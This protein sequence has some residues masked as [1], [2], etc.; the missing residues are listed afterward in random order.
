MTIS[1]TLQTLQ[2]AFQAFLAVGRQNIAKAQ[3]KWYYYNYSCL[4][5]FHIFF[6]IFFTFSF[7]PFSLSFPF[8]FF[9][10]FF[11]P[12]FFLFFL[13]FSF[14]SFLFFLF[15]FVATFCP[16]T[17]ILK[18]MDDKLRAFFTQEL[19]KKVSTGTGMEAEFHN[20]NDYF[21]KTFPEGPAREQ[22]FKDMKELWAKVVGVAPGPNA[23]PVA[24][25]VPAA[26]TED[27]EAGTPLRLHLWNFPLEVRGYIRGATCAKHVLENMSTFLLEKNKTEVFPLETAPEFLGLR[28]GDAITDASVGV[29]GGNAVVMG[30]NLLVYGTMKLNLFDTTPDGFKVELANKLRRVLRLYTVW[31]YEPDLDSI[32]FSSIATKTKATK[33]ATVS[34]LNVSHAYSILVK[35]DIGLPGNRKSTAELMM[36]YIAK[37]NKREK[38]RGCKFNSVRCAA[39]K[40]LASIPEDSPCRQGCLN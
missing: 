20:I 8:F 2:T 15:S 9:L 10:F 27:L 23:L 16:P 32:V 34:L 22:Y 35:R 11:F 37:H 19:A 31:K 28:P 33:R 36:M 24:T 30:S 6:R 21:C 18:A 12:F 40:L 1:K 38:T 14:L 3:K 13:F 25:V 7:F 5:K 29:S 4:Q 39:I 17:D 26:P